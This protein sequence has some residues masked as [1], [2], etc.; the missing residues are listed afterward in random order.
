MAKLHR[1]RVI[2]KRALRPLSF[3][4]DIDLK[5]EDVA[6]ARKYIKN[7]W[8]KV[9]RFHPKDDESLLGLPK[10][11]LVPSYRLKTGFDYN[12][13]YYWDSYFMVQGMLD[14]EHEE[15]VTGILDDLISLYRRFKV[16]PNASRTY[17]TGRSQPPLLT[18]FIFD[19]YQAYNK[20]NKWLKDKMAIAEEEYK[21]VWLGVKK[22]NERQV[23]NGLSRYYDI[24][25]LHDLAEAESGWDMT[26]RFDRRALNFL[27]IDLNSLLYK[28]ET[29]FARTARILGD[30]RKAA[31]WDDAARVRKDVIDTLMWDKLRSMYFDYNYVRK[32]RGDVF[33][34]A[35]FFPLW[36]GMVDEERAA[37]LVKSLKRFEHKGGLSTTDALPLKQF[38]LGSVPTQWA[39]PNGWAPLHFIVVKGLERYGYHK[40]ARRIA[41]KW[42]KTNLHWFNSENLF[43]EKYNVVNPEKP[44]VK[45]LYPSQTGFGWTNAVFERFAQDYVD[46][47]E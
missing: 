23:Y 12:E 19:V 25:Y 32:K 9:E 38:V 46:R 39:Y 28:Y 17:L 14:P 4:P 3:R 22:P 6:E 2:V 18:S 10:P 41:N 36:A 21:T 27:P 5:P 30:K 31:Y 29:D 26:P 24:N 45:G 20:S 11:Y 44:P 16:I 13:L 37:T 43:L 15:L 35:A 40:D 1:T 47:P 8:S 34:L 7:Y 42:L 33:S